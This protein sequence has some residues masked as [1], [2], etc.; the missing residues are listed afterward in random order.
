[1]MRSLIVA[2]CVL[3]FPCALHAQIDRMVNNAI[4][5]VTLSDA[6][7]SAGLK[8]TLRLGIQNAVQSFSQGKGYAI[9]MPDKLQGLQQ[10]L[11]AVGFGPKIDAFIL[12]MNKV[13]QK[14]TPSAGNMFL[15]ALENTNFSD[16]K[17]IMQ[18]SD[19]AATEYFKDKTYG[20]LFESLRPL[21]SAKMKE[22]GVLDKYNELVAGYRS[23][24]LIGKL[25]NFDITQYVTD[26]ALSGMFLAVGQQERTIRND[27]EAQVTG[28]L[29]Q[30]FG[31]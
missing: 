17:K 12:G 7:V 3:F 22:A 10:A 19:T 4:K 20:Q 8:E 23:L 13:A 2:V 21:V 26:K 6:T 28:L 24:P 9:G 30:V 14:L 5:Q 15:R 16:A 1:M 11:R 18:G 25:S 27:P 29:Q 31:K